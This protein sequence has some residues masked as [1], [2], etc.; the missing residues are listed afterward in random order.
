MTPR[1]LYLQG[2]LSINGRDALHG[3]ALYDGF[4]NVSEESILGHLIYS[5][6]D[7]AAVTNPRLIPDIVSHRLLRDFQPNI[8]FVEGGLFA[9]AEGHWKIPEDMADQFCR[10]GN[11][12][13]VADIDVNEL[14]QKKEHYWKAGKFFQA[15]ARY[16]NENSSDPVYGT[17]RVR[18]WRGQRQILCDPKKMI[19]SDWIRPIYDDIPEILVGLPVCLANW[20]SLAASCNGD[21]TGTLC[22]D[23]WI[24]EVDSCPFA[25]VTQIGSG[26]AVF[27]A[28]LVSGDA[29]LQGCR[30]N[31]KWLLNMARFLLDQA[32]EEK[33]RR[34]S[35]RRSPHLLFLSH[36][37]I[38]KKKVSATAQAI[39]KCGVNVW[40]DQEQLVPS[41]SLTA[42]ISKAL[43]K[44][45]AFVLFWS[46]H[47]IGAPWVERELNSA[48]ALL[49]KEKIPLLIVRFDNTPVPPI[50][51]DIYRIEG[52]N[53][54]PEDLGGQI[55]NAIEML[56]NAV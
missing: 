27:I 43:G 17:D 5:D 10:D 22:L 24:D 45:T 53:E 7:A 46:S 8:I 41:Q 35:H 47:C 25:A 34:L 13:I 30:H 37:S 20:Q 39:K 31:T 54:T 52:V 56:K 42:E 48:I 38:D 55:A 32:S 9:T 14:H 4:K 44:M 36:R 33:A 29:W 16:K 11:V 50:I 21:T 1:T 26:F 6:E 49:I 28:A 40:L 3:R 51:A 19:V 12:L 15:Y 23:R 18:H 2:M